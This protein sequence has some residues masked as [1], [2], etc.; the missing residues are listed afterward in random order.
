MRKLFKENI[1][2]NLMILKRTL[3]IATM[4]TWPPT[5]KTF[6]TFQLSVAK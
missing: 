1:K 2:Q 3:K 5:I 4:D 6:P